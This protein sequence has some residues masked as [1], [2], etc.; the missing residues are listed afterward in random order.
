MYVGGPKYQLAR[1]QMRTVARPTIVTRSRE[2]FYGLVE[3]LWAV[4]AQRWP[5]LKVRV[6]R[7]GASNVLPEKPSAR[8]RPV[9]AATPST[10]A[11][12]VSGILAGLELIVA[13]LH[14]GEG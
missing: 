2:P 13:E 7:G 10:C 14:Q 4:V 6:H 8:I 1:V 11:R 12:P 5:V 9:R 3:C